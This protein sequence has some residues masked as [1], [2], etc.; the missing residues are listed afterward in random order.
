MD[1]FPDDEKAPRDRMLERKQASDN[2]MNLTRCR[3]SA[4]VACKCSTQK[5]SH[6]TK[7]KFPVRTHAKGDRNTREFSLACADIKGALVKTNKT[8]KTH[9]YQPYVLKGGEL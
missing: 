1:E 7:N 6:P 3:R 9:E 4:P 2:I 8:M 5:S